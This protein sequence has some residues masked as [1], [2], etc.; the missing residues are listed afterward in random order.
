[1][2]LMEKTM[3]SGQTGGAFN[4]SVA[5]IMRLSLHLLRKESNAVL[6]N[7]ENHL[8]RLQAAEL[9]KQGLKMVQEKG[10]IIGN[11]ASAIKLKQAV[12]L[13]IQIEK[14]KAEASSQDEMKTDEPTY[15]E[16]SLLQD[17]FISAPT[18]AKACTPLREF[19]E[20]VQ[21]LG[22]IKTDALETVEI[23]LRRLEGSEMETAD[24]K[25]LREAL[26]I[27]V[28]VCEGVQQ[29]GGVIKTLADASKYKNMLINVSSLI[30]ALPDGPIS[31]IPNDVDT[32][33]KKGQPSGSGSPPTPKRA[34]S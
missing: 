9:L 25:S 7:G 21:F 29:K 16:H 3:E 5:H 31:E 11:I 8:T 34:R 6:K 32:A 33:M 28:D 26:P 13:L 23:A 10:G 18:I 20:N 19:A 14:Q 4:L 30:E 17:T 12:E 22:L 15:T 1:M 2:S 27:L 24:K